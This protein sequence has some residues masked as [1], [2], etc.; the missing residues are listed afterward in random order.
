[1][2]VRSWGSPWSF[3]VQDEK[4]RVLILA[5]WKTL[6][7]G[8]NSSAFR[9]DLRSAGIAGT[10]SPHLALCRAEALQD[11]MHAEETCYHLSSIS[12]IFKK[13]SLAMLSAE[14]ELA[15][16]LLPLLHSSFCFLL[17]SPALGPPYCTLWRGPLFSPLFY[18]LS[19]P[20]WLGTESNPGDRGCSPSNQA[21]TCGHIFLLPYRET[22][23][24]Q[25]Q[26]S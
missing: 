5:M 25:E 18:I 4:N 10:L 1:M 26:V 13:A 20:Y 8:Q 23:L 22:L 24:K 19:L 17:G 16:S 2:T 6:Q 12:S 14:L 7:L 21:K 11:V 15:R 3:P 9:L